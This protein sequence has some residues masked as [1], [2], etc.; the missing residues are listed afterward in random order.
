MGSTGSGRFSDYPGSGRGGEGG[1]GSGSE[2]EVQQDR[3]TRAFTANLQDVEHSQYYV[4]TSALPPVGTQLTIELRKRVA[5]VDAAGNSVGS[6]PTPFNYLADCLTAGF[7]YA[8]VVTASSAGPSA[9]VKVDFGV[10]P[11]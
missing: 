9:I 8:G 5:A 10:V 1:S 2:D 4:R 7:R 3:C 6:L 11:G